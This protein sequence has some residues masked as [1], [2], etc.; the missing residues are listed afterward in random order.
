MADVAEKQRLGAV[1]F[2]ERLGAFLLVFVS[3]RIRDARRDLSSNEFERASVTHI[4][5][6]VWIEP[7]HNDPRRSG[8]GLARHWKEK[9]PVRRDIPRSGWQRTEQLP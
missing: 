3:T 9:C 6:T 4:E 8:L 2:R 5:R 1:D 7:N